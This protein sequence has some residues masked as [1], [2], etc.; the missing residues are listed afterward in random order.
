L[1]TLSQTP[2]SKHGVGLVKDCCSALGLLQSFC[3]GPQ[4]Y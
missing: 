1:P 3:S 4:R 2:S